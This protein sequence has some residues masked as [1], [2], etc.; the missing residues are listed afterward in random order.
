MQLQIQVNDAGKLDFLLQLLRE[1][2]FVE[3]L[4]PSNGAAS[5]AAPKKKQLTP[6]QLKE[7]AEIRE[8]LE[9]IELH[10]QGKIKLQS[11]REFLAEL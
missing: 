1:F 5:K 2:S 4:L 8:A 7:A 10:V 3:V 11:A 9:E 6:F